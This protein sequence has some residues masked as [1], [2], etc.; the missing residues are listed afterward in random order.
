M[1]TIT[2]KLQLHYHAWL[3]F[4]MHSE[5]GRCLEVRMPPDQDDL[6][7][8]LKLPVFRLDRWWHRHAFLGLCRGCNGTNLG[9]RKHRRN[10]FNVGESQNSP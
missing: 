8:M 3:R 2:A 10:G 4:H 1:L 9:L 6:T 7:D 5:L